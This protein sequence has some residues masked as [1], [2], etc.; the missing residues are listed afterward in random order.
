MMNTDLSHS[1]ATSGSGGTSQVFEDAESLSASSR[2]ARLFG[3]P[4]IDVKPL[5]ANI[6]PKLRVLSE[7][8]AQAGAYKAQ[9]KRWPDIYY[10]DYFKPSI[11]VSTTSR[12]NTHCEQKRQNLEEL[13]LDTCLNEDCFNHINFVEEM[14][15]KYSIVSV[16]F[17]GSQVLP[18]T[19]TVLHQALRTH[20]KV[21]NFVCTV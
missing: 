5:L 2:T 13:G 7:V 9:R 4:I 11:E 3:S 19:G 15:G 21:W 20:C 14:G 16:K 1:L 10:D 8:P 12:C 6:Q 17:E 18:K